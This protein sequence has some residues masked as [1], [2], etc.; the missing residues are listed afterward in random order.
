ML[1][2]VTELED[3]LKKNFK[4]G[5]SKAFNLEDSA[6]LL[7]MLSRHYTPGCS[8]TY[9]VITLKQEWPSFS[10]ALSDALSFLSWSGLIAFTR[11]DKSAFCLQQPLLT[12]FNQC[13]RDG[14]A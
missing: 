13:Y 8:L 7:F 12:F 14:R 3:F 5:S 6:R 11:K 10:K 4:E 9:S 2:S 1:C